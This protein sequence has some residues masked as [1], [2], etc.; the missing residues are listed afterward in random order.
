MLF[1]ISMKLNRF[2]I[3]LDISLYF[4]Q[5]INNGTWKKYFRTLYPSNCEKKIAKKLLY[6]DMYHLISLVDKSSA[7]SRRIKTVQLSMTCK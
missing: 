5:C 2:T 3:S 4:I 6:M 1:I 7:E